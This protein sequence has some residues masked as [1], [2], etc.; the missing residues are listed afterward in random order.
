MKWEDQSDRERTSV[1]RS[2]H[3]AQS[4][5]RWGARDLAALTSRSCACLKLGRHCPV[6]LRPGG[7]RSI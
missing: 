1:R 5:S 2:L 3:A 6:S 4:S 7:D